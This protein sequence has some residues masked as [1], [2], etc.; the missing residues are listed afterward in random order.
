MVRILIIVSIMTFFLSA[1]FKTNCVNCHTKNRVNLRQTFMSAL[2]VYGS[3]K[4][5]KTALFYYCKNPAS[6]TSV[7]DEWFLSEHKMP[8]SIKLN[9]K[10]LD[11]M[12]EIYWERYKVRK[13]LK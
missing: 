8:T 5:F 10:E 2:L 7:M 9:D 3:K 12:L 13:K 4:S 6:M 11:K 1:N